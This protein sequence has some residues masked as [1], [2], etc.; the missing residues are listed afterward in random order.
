MAMTTKQHRVGLSILWV[1]LG[2]FTVLSM[3]CASTRPTG[4]HEKRI[5]HEAIMTVEGVDVPNRLVTVRGASGDS[6][7]V[8][9]DPSVKSFPQ[10]G[11]GDRVR[12]RYVESIAFQLTK[13]GDPIGNYQVKE[14][15]A[16]PGAGR[17][18][19]AA[20]TEIKTTVRIE[21][22]DQAGSRVTFTG[23]RG[24]R[25]VQ[26]QDPAMRDYTSKLRPGDNVDVTYKEALALSLEKVKT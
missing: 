16:K 25:T 24:R 7:T 14:E 13:A 2:A 6:L 21:S 22:V 26:I 8:Y 20:S 12:V 18:A 10:A 4:A 1:G 15:T 5:E 19:G 3:G 23:P 9:V 17:P 11:V